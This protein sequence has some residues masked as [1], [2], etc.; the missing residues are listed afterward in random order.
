M[1][2]VNNVSLS[3]GARKLFEDVSIKISKEI[4]TALLEQMV[5]EN[6]PS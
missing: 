3:F 5:L 6:Q 4:V 1:I 2:T